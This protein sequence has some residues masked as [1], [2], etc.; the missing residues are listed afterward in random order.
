MSAHTMRLVLGVLFLLLG[1]L[2]LT[3]R[4]VMPDVGAG[5]DPTRMTLG[6]ILALVFAG[7]NFA[8]WYVA[9]AYL[10]DRSTPVRTPLQPDPTMTPPDPPNPDF[11]FTE[12]KQ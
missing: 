8:R 5:F 1:V 7:L 4:W 6:G 9:R 3:R 2:I 10:R 11:D 12:K